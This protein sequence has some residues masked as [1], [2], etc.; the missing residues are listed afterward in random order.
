MLRS[1]LRSC[2]AA[3]CTALAL[4]S[5]ALAQPV[6]II[7]DASDDMTPD[8]QAIV[9]TILDA[10][11]DGLIHVWRRTIGH[12]IYG[13]AIPY[14][15]GRLSISD[16]RRYLS[17]GLW[18]GLFG[19]FNPPFGY[20]TPLSA[21]CT[22]SACTVL[23]PR[24]CTGIPLRG[25]SSC[26]PNACATLAVGPTTLG[27]CCNLGG[28]VCTVTTRAACPSPNY[29]FGDV[30]SCGTNPCRRGH[31]VP[32]R[33]DNSTGQWT[34][35]GS[36]AN[37]GGS[38]AAVCDANIAAP[39]D[40]SGNGRFIT[41]SGLYGA[42][43]ATSCNTRGFMTDAQT[44][45][46]YELPLDFTGCQPFT[47]GDR[48]SSNGL[49][50]V[51]TH[52][53]QGDADPA[54]ITAPI[55]GTCNV[56]TL[57]VWERPD[58]TSNFTIPNRTE[59]DRFGGGGLGNMVMTRSGSVIAAALS[60]DAAT[61][62]VGDSNVGNALVTYTKVAGVWTRT[63]IGF[64]AD[65]NRNF[66][67]L[68]RAISDDG[69]TIFGNYSGGQFIWRP[70]INGGVPM[71]LAAYLQS[72]NGGT[73]FFPVSVRDGISADGNAITAQISLSAPGPQC[74]SPIGRRGVLYLTPQPCEQ[75]RIIGGPYS[76]QQRE[77]TTFGIVGNVFFSGTYP[78][79]WQWQREE[80][81]GSG[82]WVNI[83]DSCANFVANDSWA[84]E[85]TTGPQLRVNML[86]NPIDRDRNFRVILTNSCGTATSQPAAIGAVTGACCTQIGGST[87]CSIQLPTRCTSSF[88]LGVAGIYRGDGTTC[89]PTACDGTLGA[90]CIGSGGPNAPCSLAIQTYCTQTVASGG[91]AGAFVGANTVCGPA[92][93]GAIS[94]A[95]CYSSSGGS[96]AVCTL[97]T[98][99][100]CSRSV[101]QGGLGGEYRGNATTCSP[102][103]ACN[104]VLGACCAPPNNTSSIVCTLQTSARCIN[105]LASGGLQGLFGGAGVTCSPAD[106]CNFFAGACCYTP[107]GQSNAICTIQL[108]SVCTARVNGQSVGGVII[109]GL[110]GVY[111]GDG[112]T[113]S[114]TQCTSVVGACCYQP[115]GEICRICAVTPEVRCT[116]PTN[117]GGLNGSYG[118][119]NT[120][121]SPAGCD[122]QLGRC[123][124][125]PSCEVSCEAVC[126]A[127]GGTFTLNATC[128]PGDCGGS[129]NVVC[130][131]GSTC[132]LVPSANCTVA[133]QF[134]AGASQLAGTSCN[135][136]GN[137]TTPCC[138]GDYNKN[139]QV[140]GDVP[141]IFAFLGDWFSN[142]PYAFVGGDGNGTGS[143]GVPA[144]FAFL[145][146]W[147]AGCN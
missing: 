76:V 33:F 108:Q 35:L 44:G 69:N 109:T 13:P 131:R 145:G 31:D 55:A 4:T 139:G 75:P 57:T 41:G 86:A 10:N 51:G 134:V 85:G 110:S 65:A 121:C 130:C 114:P 60:R 98:Q 52:T 6:F 17:G 111:R 73:P 80:P 48:V 105:N 141:D 32:H 99:L 138:H 93:C 47:Q 82:T 140:A 8:G 39:F 90:C 78:L 122:L 50:V 58:L 128:A 126:T 34:N 12:T 62:D 129:A 116:T 87:A 137:S 9:G 54:G 64:V 20:Y 70:S 22:G 37:V 142:S 144:I 38:G 68:P 92:A 40:M 101:A 113:C 18:N 123:C 27:A 5:A 133:G 83:S 53:R 102:V 112:S 28:N 11:V 1:R 24:F 61:F 97:E 91:L 127:S 132:S 67:M 43:G 21:C 26:T 117:I 36:F 79:T 2:I 120:T 89:S 7:T 147:F 104:A 81:T 124:L 3:V 115:I 135:A 71:N 46:V 103:N 118:G 96:N 106:L 66:A 25:T 136:S 45:T 94:G 146:A 77:Y 49:I 88:F 19:A 63:I 59:L 100:H 143:P 42:Y 72:I 23:E 14:I 16:D 15:D 107:V 30:A 95:C 29:W 74:L 125:N 84:Y 119:G 56:R